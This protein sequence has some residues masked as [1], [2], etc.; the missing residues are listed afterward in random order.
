MQR[1]EVAQGRVRWGARG[2]KKKDLS[3]A[4][5]GHWPPRLEGASL[6]GCE[7]RE[8]FL[9][10]H[11]HVRRLVVALLRLLQGPTGDDYGRE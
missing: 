1:V 11:D 8:F 10:L 5:A 2:R 7:L 4:G 9:E 3:K 6:T